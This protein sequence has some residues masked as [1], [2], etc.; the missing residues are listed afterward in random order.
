MAVEHDH[1]HM[2][3]GTPMKS[4]K[5]DAADKTGKAQTGASPATVNPRIDPK[6]AGKPAP[7]TR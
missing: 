6:V 2:K 7:K 3:P 4:E 5:G 1:E